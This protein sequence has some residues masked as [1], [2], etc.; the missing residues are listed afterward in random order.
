MRI[1][2]SIQKRRGRKPANPPSAEAASAAGNIVSDQLSLF[3]SAF[4]LSADSGWEWRRILALQRILRTDPDPVMPSLSSFKESSREQETSSHCPLS[5]F[6]AVAPCPA[7]AALL[8][9][10]TLPL[11]C[12]SG[13]S[14]SEFF[15]PDLIPRTKVLFSPAFPSAGRRPGKNPRGEKQGKKEKGRKR[16]TNQACP[17]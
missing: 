13:E 8:L 16:Q 14:S 10:G 1:S 15:L 12:S 9:P 5:I 17:P 11:H 6:R 3:P 2:S 4:S 7:A